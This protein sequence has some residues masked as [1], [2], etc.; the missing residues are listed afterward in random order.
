MRSLAYPLALLLVVAIP[1][2]A[3]G[4]LA[5]AELWARWMVR[6]GGL[7]GVVGVALTAAFAV[8]LVVPRTCSTEP[9]EEVN[10][11]AISLVVGDGDCFRHALG[12]TQLA[13]LVGVAASVV[14]VTRSARGGAGGATAVP[15]R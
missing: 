15:S 1:V 13:V 10:R 2:A 14:V 5:G 11:P 6:A 3:L 9:V 7:L 4:L 12:Q 8:N